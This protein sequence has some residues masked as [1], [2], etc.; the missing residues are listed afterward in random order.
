MS[1]TNLHSFNGPELNGQL[2]ELPGA[3]TPGP[4]I[5]D[6]IKCSTGLC[7][8]L[9]RFGT[10]HAGQEDALDVNN[11]R[12]LDIAASKWVI[13]GAKYGITIKGG[14]SNIWVMGEVEGRGQECDVDLG[15]WSDQSSEKTGPV[16][17]NLWRADGSPVR[18]RVLNSMRPNLAAGLP[19]QWVFPSPNI[20]FHSL[21]VK[22]FLWFRRLFG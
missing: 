5:S 2:V 16:L 11:C 19:Y 17:I 21:F 22:A 20:W 14:S 13:G 10:V 1:D 18:V 3:I 6:T 9:F 8:T 7:G 4:E 12:D 15:N